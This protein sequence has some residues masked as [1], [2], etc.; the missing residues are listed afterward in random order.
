MERVYINI[1]QQLRI[2]SIA[3]T[4]ALAAGAARGQ[5][6]LAELSGAVTASGGEMLPGVAV[7]ARD[8]N[9]GNRRAAT[10]SDTGTYAIAGLRPGTYVV[11][12]EH[13]GFTT[14]ENRGVEM[15]LGRS[16]SARTTIAAAS[17]GVC[18]GNA[19]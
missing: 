6:A 19:S 2:C 13:A 15:R 7:T 5:F 4:L 8:V 10:T 3:L 18:V 11:T 16:V 9:T 1:I 14:V 17:S 12:F